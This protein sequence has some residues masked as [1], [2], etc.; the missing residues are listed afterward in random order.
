MSA[1]REFSAYIFCI[2]YFICDRTRFS[3]YI[4][5]HPVYRTLVEFGKVAK[6]RFL[7]DYLMNEDLRIEIH[8]SQNIVERLNSIMGFI[9]YG[10]VGEINSNDKDDQELAQ[11]IM[12]VSIVIC[13]DIGKKPMPK[14][15]EQKSC[16]LQFAIRMRKWRLPQH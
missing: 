9:F 11:P 12:G 3:H 14:K 13:I 10:K 4:F 5:Q 7:C 6:T 16:T 1:S 8:E 15:P 2:T